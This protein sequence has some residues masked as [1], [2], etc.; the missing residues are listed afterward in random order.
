LAF[1][2]FPLHPAGGPSDQRAQHLFATKLPLL[3]LQGD[4][5]GLARIDL[6]LP[7]IQRL[8][9][10][11]T[12]KLIENADHSFRVPARLQRDGPPILALLVQTMLDWTQS[13]IDST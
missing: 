11:A 10:R 6:L 5:D 7:V 1:L 3:F 12:L 8:G 9:G 2:G 4:R 13:L